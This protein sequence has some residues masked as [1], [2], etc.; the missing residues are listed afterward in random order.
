MLN[1]NDG[2]TK[3]NDATGYSCDLRGKPK[4][5]GSFIP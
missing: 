3:L 4:P 2:R 5:S 1:A